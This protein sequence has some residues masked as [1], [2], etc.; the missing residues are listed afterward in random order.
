M[1]LSLKTEKGA[2]EC[3]PSLEAR[4]AKETDFLRES[5]ER[6]I[7]LPTPRLLV[8]QDLRQT[9]NLQNCR[10]VNVCSFK[11]LN[12]WQSVKAAIGN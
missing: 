4:K 12:L 2:K 6:N 8:H 1:F 3:K 10:I 5:P 11:M 7:A 9:S